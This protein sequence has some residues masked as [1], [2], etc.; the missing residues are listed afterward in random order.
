[1]ERSEI[2][3]ALIHRPRVALRFT[4]ATDFTRSRAGRTAA[5][6]TPLRH[7]RLLFLKPR[8]VAGFPPAR[9]GLRTDSK[10]LAANAKMQ[11]FRTFRGSRKLC[12]PGG[13]AKSHKHVLV[14]QPKDAQT[15]ACNSCHIVKRPE[16]EEDALSLD[17]DTRSG[18]LEFLVGNA[19][20]YPR[21]YVAIGFAMS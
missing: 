3:G 4:R 5:V 2:R 10:I 1:M 19:G 20:P 16:R 12:W 6:T 21:S 9:N 13:M 15:L 11:S 17:H 18:P 7:S 8:M 14:V